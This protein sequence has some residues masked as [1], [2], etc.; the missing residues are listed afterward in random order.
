MDTRNLTIIIS[1]VWLLLILT[2]F[3]WNYTNLRNEQN[4]IV[5]FNAR[6]FANMVLLSREW[7]ARHTLYVKVTD[8]TKPNKYLIDP[9][10][11]LRVGDITLTMMNP[12]YMTRQ[13]S[14]ISNERDV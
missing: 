3:Y 11:D 4:T 7:N 13:I 14:E 12:A 6:S 8:R 9:K 1:I 2:S 5:L 10:R